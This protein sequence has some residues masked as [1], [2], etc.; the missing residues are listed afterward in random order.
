MANIETPWAVICP[1][2][3]LTFLNHEQYMDQ[4]YQSDSFWKCPICGNYSEWS[5]ENYESWIMENEAI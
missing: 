5:D 2:H 4:M 1:E 3:G